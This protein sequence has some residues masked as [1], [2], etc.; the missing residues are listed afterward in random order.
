MLTEEVGK[1]LNIIDAITDNLKYY[2]SKTDEYEQAIDK[3]TE[4]FDN[5][6]IIS[7]CARNVFFARRFHDAMGEILKISK[8]QIA[9]ELSK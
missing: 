9:G 4:E 3:H 6:E 1:Y 8:I 2:E 5:S 7:D